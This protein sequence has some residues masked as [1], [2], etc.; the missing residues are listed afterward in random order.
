M[1]PLHSCIG[2]QIYSFPDLARAHLRKYP[3]YALYRLGYHKRA[4]VNGFRA[5]ASTILDETGFGPD[6]IERQLAHVERNK[7]RAAYN[8]SEY[9]EERQKMM[10]W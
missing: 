6:V 4:T 8:K 2:L 7:V 10:D 3:F 9:L 1:P 5:M